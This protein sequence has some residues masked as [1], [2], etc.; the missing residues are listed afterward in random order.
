MLLVAARAEAARTPRV[1]VDSARTTSLRI[2]FSLEDRGLGVGAEDLLQ[3]FD[4][5]AFGGVYARAVQKVRHQVDPGAG[6]LTGELGQR[7]L[8]G[9]AVAAGADCLD[10]LFLLAFERRV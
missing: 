6:R 9:G 8:D 3:G 1:A 10:A 4:D 7:A 2:A 5:L